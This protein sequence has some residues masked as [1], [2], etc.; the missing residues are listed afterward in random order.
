[1]NTLKKLS[2]LLA[3]TLVAA[4]SSGSAAVKVGQPAPD[5]SL[6]DTD[7]K[8]HSL[9][10]LKGKTVVLEW[11]NPDCPFV[12]KHYQSGNMPK[13]QKAAARDG[14][15]WLLVESGAG[16]APAKAQQWQQEQGAQ[17]AAFL[18]DPDGKVGRNYAAKTTPHL[19]VI[20]PEGVL[21]YQGAIDSIR[22]ADVKDIAKAKNY[23]VAALDAV[24]AGKPVEEATTQPYGC[25]VKY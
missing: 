6:T 13:L 14:V 16:R 25:A 23:V 4:V 11:T 22:S 20:S 10:D 1:M 9:A 18:R 15:V 21:V 12:Q 8:V 3:A 24:K 19:Y 17:V 5:F 2:F 7:G